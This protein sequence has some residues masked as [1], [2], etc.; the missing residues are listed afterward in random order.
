MSLAFLPSPALL[1]FEYSRS[2][3]VDKMLRNMTGTNPGAKA[4]L[5]FQS[6]FIMANSPMGISGSV[7]FNN[8]R[9]SLNQGACSKVPKPS[10]SP[11]S[12]FAAQISTEERRVLCRS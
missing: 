2:I 10:G 7:S 8:N 11:A 3:P 1:F 5:G 6:K 4:C 9:F 12:T